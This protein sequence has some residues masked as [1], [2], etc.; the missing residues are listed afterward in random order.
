MFQSTSVHIA[1]RNGCKDAV[2]L[3]IENKANVNEK[4]ISGFT[5][6]MYGK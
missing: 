6:L 1:S 2:K 4:D 3:L 5:G